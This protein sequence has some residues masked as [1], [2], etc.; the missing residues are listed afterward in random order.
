M[1]RIIGMP[2]FS[3]FYFNLILAFETLQ[4][5]VRRVYDLGVTVCVQDIRIDFQFDKGIFD[6]KFLPFKFPYPVPFK[7]LGD[8]TKAS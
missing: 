6:F 5:L 1:K 3:H 8:E 7:L 2:T 4:R